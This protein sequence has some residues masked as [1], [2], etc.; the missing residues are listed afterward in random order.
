L[1]GTL[2]IFRSGS[3]EPGA[4]AMLVLTRKAGE[5]IVV[6]QCQLTLTVLDI[7]AGRVR[8][9]VSAPPTVGV[10]RE[11]IQRR[12]ATTPALVV[13]ETL[14]SARILIADPDRFLLASYSRHLR[15]RGVTVSTATTGLECTERLRGAVPDVL[16]LEPAMLWGGGDGVLAMMNDEPEL[17]P[18]VVILLTQ[19]RNRNLLYRLSSFKVDDYQTKPLTAEQLTTRIRTLLAFC[20]D[21]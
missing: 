3:L 17:R 8:L 11:E 18:H 5:K 7:T 12:I 6:P 4:I 10:Y 19:G 21:C 9:G 13:G 16:V 14:M 1:N 20:Q 15:E 2:L